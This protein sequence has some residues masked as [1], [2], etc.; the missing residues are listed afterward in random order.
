MSNLDTEEGLLVHTIN[1][2]PS[3]VERKQI[4]DRQLLM[5]KKVPDP[6][7]LNIICLGEN[8][9]PSEGLNY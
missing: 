1:E 6:N 2:N 9:Y 3:S 5:T 8:Q 7:L 4:N